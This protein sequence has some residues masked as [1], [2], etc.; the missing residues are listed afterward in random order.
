MRTEIV[1]LH[2]SLQ[3]T[4]IY[5]THDQT[6]AMTMATRLVVINNGEIQQVGTPKEVYEKPVNVFVGRFIGSPPMNF[7]KGV[8]L[9]GEFRVGHVCI[10]IPEKQVMTLKRKGYMNKEMIMGIRPEDIHDA[11]SVLNP[12]G[13]HNIDG[14]IKAIES[15]GAEHLVH[16]QIAG[17]PFI[18]RLDGRSHVLQDQTLKLAFNMNRVHFFD[19]L[20]ESRIF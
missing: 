17:Q 19:S 13:H 14:K 4:T 10:P 12:S 18:A 9:D 8:L 16:S 5:V 3:T 6:E 15:L 11:A 20:T 1:K 2:Q 7:F